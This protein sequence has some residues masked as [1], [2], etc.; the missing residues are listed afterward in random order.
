[1]DQKSFEKRAI[2]K[3]IGYRVLEMVYH[4]PNDQELG[5]KIR[6]LVLNLL[7]M[8]ELKDEFNKSNPKNK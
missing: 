3:K 1:M 2:H 8:K 7:S 5:R 6:R 4:T